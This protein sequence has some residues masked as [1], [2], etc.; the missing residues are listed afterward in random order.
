MNLNQITIEWFKKHSEQ[1]ICQY[2]S[3]PICELLV[4][5]IMQEDLLKTLQT[6]RKVKS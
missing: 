3:C 5:P 6:E 2:A 4:N 1:Q